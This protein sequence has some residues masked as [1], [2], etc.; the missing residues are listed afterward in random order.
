MTGRSHPTPRADGS[1]LRA[2][3]VVFRPPETVGVV[4]HQ[5]GK[6]RE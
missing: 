4:E 6:E 1:E 2:R 3:H 5:S